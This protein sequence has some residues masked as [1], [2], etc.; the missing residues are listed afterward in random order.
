MRLAVALFMILVVAPGDAQGQSRRP[1]GAASEQ[2]P[3]FLATT[4]LQT[5]SLAASARDSLAETGSS[6]GDPITD[7]LNAIV[8]QRGAASRLKQAT[9]LLEQFRGSPDEPVR[10]A[11][12]DLST[13]YRALAEKLLSGVVI[14]EK[15]AKTRTA[16]DI[17]ALV[18]ETGKN[19][20]E[21][22]EAWRLLPVGVAGVSHALV[23]SERLT[24][25]KISHLRLTRSERARLNDEIKALFPTV[26]PQDKGG[27]VVDVSVNLFRGFLNQPWR[28]SDD[29]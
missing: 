5:L 12:E 9:A 7:S 28:S 15:F 25:G 8:V 10:T 13:I 27:Q 18:P 2:T 6:T 24:D 29:K 22:Q 1:S 23:D 20:A 21:I 14:W 19:A 26:K 11:A 3:Y 17:A 16:E 4:L